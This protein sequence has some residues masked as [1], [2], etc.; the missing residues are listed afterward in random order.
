M[1]SFLGLLTV[2]AMAGLA[3]PKVKNDEE[4]SAPSKERV[5]TFPEDRSIGQVHFYDPEG[6]EDSK[7]SEKVIEAKGRVVVPAGKH[8]G[9][10]F[11]DP[12]QR[13]NTPVD[14][15]AL[16]QLEPDDLQFLGIPFSKIPADSIRRLKRHRSL[17][18]L[19]LGPLSKVTDDSLAPLT[20]MTW[21]E[22]LRLPEAD[23][24]DAGLPHLGKLTKLKVLSLQSTE[25]TD[26]GLI[27]LKPLTQMQLLELGD[28]RITDEGL[29]HL[30]GM[31]KLE[32]LELGRHVEGPGL[33]HLKEMSKL[34]TLRL[35]GTR[36][37]N[38]D[39]VRL[40]SLTNLEELDLRGT[41]IDDAGLVHLANLRKLKMLRLWGT[42][43]T[44]EG[45]EKLKQVLK[46]CEIP[47]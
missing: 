47:R 41:K 31:K 4:R 1:K 29:K 9:L 36:I 12:N 8:L 27:H 7:V 39:L 2:L 46:N 3:L 26:D 5:V 33:V 44:D 20:E 32:Y 22:S 10:L 37:R 21:L 43:V 23:V 6:L 42:K 24:S 34:K 38:E 11:G 15:S 19:L 40:K 28:T 35:A 45:V 13:Q 17:K 16:D 25:I 18:H 14:L 30:A